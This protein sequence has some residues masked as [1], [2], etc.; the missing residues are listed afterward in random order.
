MINT[1]LCSIGLAFIIIINP[2]PSHVKKTEEIVYV[3]L[4]PKAYA[5]HNNHCRGL[6]KCSHKI[7]KMNVT[8]AKALG[9]RMCRICY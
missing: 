6:L 8:K 5:Y 9:Y 1:I 4:S 2:E 3:C 7:A